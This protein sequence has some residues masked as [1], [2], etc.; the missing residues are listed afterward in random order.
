MYTEP[1]EKETEKSENVS[2]KQFEEEK[3][4]DYSSSNTGKQVIS[5]KFIHEEH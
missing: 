2:Y 3:K 1:L 5:S 4:E